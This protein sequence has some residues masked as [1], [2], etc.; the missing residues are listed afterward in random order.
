[1]TTHKTRGFTLTELLIVMAILGM[2]LAIVAPTTTRMLAL[3][4]RAQCMSQLH[5]IGKAYTSFFAQ[6]PDATEFGATSWAQTLWPHL[7]DHPNAAL[8]PEDR[9]PHQGLPDVTLSVTYHGLGK[10][11]DPNTRPLFSR[12]PEWDS[13]DCEHPGPGVWK[14]ND[15]DYALF[16]SRPGGE[17]A[18]DWLPKYSPGSNPNSYWI[19]IEEGLHMGLAGSDFDYD[20][21]II[22]VTELGDNRISMEF[23]KQWYYADYQLYDPE[24]L[25]VGDT[26]LSIGEP[27]NTGPFS[28]FSVERLSYGMNWRAPEITRGL[29]RIVALGYTDEVVQVGGGVSDPDDWDR[30]VAPRHLG[31]VNVL[32]ADGA[33]A[34]MDPDEIDPGEPDSTNDL[35]YWSPAP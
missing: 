30:C 3:A 22:H 4:R 20:D 8:C 6:A 35:T 32:F 29:H 23:E 1:M 9:N 34:P 28:F 18:T 12:F 14:L 24:G 16:A 25:Q 21:L 11:H 31:N 27:G 5:N 33:V 19:V 15:E 7:G 13:D 17:S 10:D 26:L 2:L